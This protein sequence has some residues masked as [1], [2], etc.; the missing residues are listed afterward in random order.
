MGI[1]LFDKKEQPLMKNSID[2]N[3]PFSGFAGTTFFNFFTSAYLFLESIT[4]DRQE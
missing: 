4:G 3:V 2:F 1:I